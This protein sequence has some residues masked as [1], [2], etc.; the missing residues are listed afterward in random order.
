M[1]PEAEEIVFAEE[2]ETQK[3][4][5]SR[6][7]TSSNPAPARRKVDPQYRFIDILEPTRR[8]ADLQNRT[9]SLDLSNQD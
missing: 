4:E 5:R 9:C 6:S 8:I 3:A 7:A 2:D 1:L